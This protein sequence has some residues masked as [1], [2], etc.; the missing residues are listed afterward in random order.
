[1]EEKKT[2]PKRH[3]RLLISKCV[4]IKGR[5]GEKEISRRGKREFETGVT[6]GEDRVSKGG[7]LVRLG[8][9]CKYLSTIA[10]DSEKRDRRGGQRTLLREGRTQVA[11]RVRAENAHVA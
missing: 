2:P 8:R 1:L 3:Y 6:E 11:E 7:K 10:R 9:H 4:V 5:E